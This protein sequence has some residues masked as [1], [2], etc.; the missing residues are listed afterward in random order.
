MSEYPSG[1]NEDRKLLAQMPMENLL[2]YFFLQIRNVWRVDGLYFLEI[3][4][5][6]G[7]DAATEIDAEVWKTIATIEAKSLQKVF[8]VSENPDASTI[9]DLLRKSSW[10][11]DQPFKTIVTNEKRTTLTVDRCRTQETRLAKGLGE[12]PC[13]KVR[14][15][16]LKAFAET[17]NSKATVNCLACPPDKHP[18]DQWCTW[19]ITA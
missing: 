14:Y 1:S 2:D 9:V 15:G 16:Y 11:L 17:L 3:E 8:K 6:F 10:T 4:K 5:R 13:K 18:K 7:V 19:E 12:F